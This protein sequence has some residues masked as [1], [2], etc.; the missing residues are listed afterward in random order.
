MLVAG[1]DEAGRGPLAGPV[2]A[3]A[4]IIPQGHFPDS[5][6]I[7]PKK[8]EELYGKILSDAT[9]V[10]VCAISPFLIDSL[11]IRKASLL[12]MRQ[13]I[14]S[15]PIT[16]DF[17]IIDGRDEIPALEIPQK[18]IIGGD[19]T[20]FVIGAASIVAKVSRDLLMKSYSS[21]Y[22]NFHFAKN[23]GYPTKEHYSDI[24]KFGITII[25]RK[26]FRLR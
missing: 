1:V 19:G 13:A 17:V 24:E 14:L 18:S 16:P 23:K 8:R 3:A 22:R 4:V 2:V 26:S 25:H 9:A 6:K 21:V 7:S 11:D 12:A 15:L 5:K 10:S 20:E